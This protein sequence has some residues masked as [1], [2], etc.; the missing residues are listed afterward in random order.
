MEKNRESSRRWRLRAAAIAA[1]IETFSQAPR[2]AWFTVAAGAPVAL[3]AGFACGGGSSSLSGLGTWEANSTGPSL[4]SKRAEVEC[5][6]GKKALG[7]GYKI[8]GIQAM[9]ARG[10][11]LKTWWS[12]PMNV[13]VPTPAFGWGAAVFEHPP[14]PSTNPADHD[15][16]IR[17]WVICAD[18]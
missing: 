10:V 14:E 17:V 1:V 12:A 9:L 2:R 11:E 4:T 16:S 5:P 13:N 8:D 6:S 3:L 7:G 18:A 15:W